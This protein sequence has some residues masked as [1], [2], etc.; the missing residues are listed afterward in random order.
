MSEV[1]RLEIV[2]SG[3]VI[4]VVK[5]SD[6]D[7]AQSELAALREELANK[8]E[9][10]SAVLGR[11]SLTE[12]RLAA[13][14]QRNAVI[15]TISED[16]YE[17]LNDFYLSVCC[18]SGHQMEK[19]MVA[20]LCEVGALESCGFG[21]HRLTKFGEYLLAQAKPTESGASE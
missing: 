5:D 20:S 11:E 1:K 12:H 9:E 2:W 14:E 4:H 19:P 7:A 3:E 16:Q 8:H 15:P 6:Y 18:D 21:K 17:G 10:F 13:A